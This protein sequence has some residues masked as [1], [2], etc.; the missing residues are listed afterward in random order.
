MQNEKT[1]S[2]QMVR[3]YKIGS[4]TYIVKSKSKPDAKEDA[5]AKVKR[6]IKGDL[7]KSFEN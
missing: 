1:L 5:V 3:K 7:R 2:P 4:T 6:L